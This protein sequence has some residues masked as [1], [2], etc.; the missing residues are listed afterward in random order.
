MRKD[1]VAVA[2]ATAI[3]LAIYYSICMAA[4]AVLTELGGIL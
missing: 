2:L 3:T 1:I 4:L